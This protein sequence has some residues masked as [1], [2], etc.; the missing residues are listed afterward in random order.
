MNVKWNT[1][2]SSFGKRIR[3]VGGA[4][5]FGD[6]S[7]SYT[8]KVQYGRQPRVQWDPYLDI[9]YYALVPKV[10][11]WAVS[12]RGGRI[13]CD[14]Q[15]GATTRVGDGAGGDRDLGVLAAHSRDWCW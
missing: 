4:S 6:A 8:D 5:V 15:E 11:L 7:G 2:S 13:R 14:V 1:R 12:R 9:L 3:K 10:S